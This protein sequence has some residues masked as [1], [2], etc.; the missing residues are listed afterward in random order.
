MP[1]FVPGIRALVLA[2]LLAFATLAHAQQQAPLVGIEPIR[3]ALDQIETTARRGASFR[4]FME[5]TQSLNPLRD[6]LRDKRADLDP[7]LADLDARLKSL[8][9][10]PAPNAPPED[11]AI[12]AERARITQQRSEIDAAIK[13]V[14]ELQTRADQLA[15][16][17][18]ERRR[19]AYSETL[20]R[21]S[22]NVLDP[23]FW[24]QVAKAL[25][26]EMDR[27]SNFAGD[28]ATY[29]RDK[30]GTARLASAGLALF[31]LMI[32]IIALARWWRR[33][34][35]IGRVGTRYGKALAALLVFARS[36]LALPLTVLIVVVLLDQFQLASPELVRALTGLIYGT[37]VASLARAT[38][39]SVLAPDDPQRRLLARDDATAQ[40]Q[41]THLIWGG[42]VVGAVV[43]LRALHSAI[44]TPA[45]IDLATRMLFAFAIATLLLHLL[46][47]RREAEDETQQ[48]Q[49]IPGVRLLAWLMIGAIVASL[50]AGY[51][52]FAAFIAGRLVFTITLIGILYLLLIVTD[53]VIARTMSAQTAGGR[54]LA[55]QLGIEPRRLDL[56]G[57]IASGLV[58]ALFVLIVIA[59]AL[60][61]WEIAASDLFD[62]L[63]GV[64][65]GIRIGDFTISFGALFG[66]IALF[67]VIAGLTKLI[68][69][70]LESEVM[71]HTAIEPSL[72]LSTVT[73]L[74]YIGYIIAVVVSLS[75]IGID[76]QKIA[77]VAG[78]LSVGIGFGL[79]S[80]VSNFVSG[81]ILLAERPIRVGDQI[82][83][84]SEEG[85]VRR[86][87]VRATEIETFER[88]SV[89]IPNSE[90]ITGVVKNWTHANTLGRVNIK[91]S[92][93]YASDPDKVMAILRACIIQHPEVL[94][95]PEPAIQLSEFGTSAMTFDI[96]CIVP[97]L[98]DRGRIKSDLH[99]AILREFRVSG[100]EMAPPQ[101]VRLIGGAA[102][103]GPKT[104]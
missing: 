96:F 34:A 87:S 12:A 98:A 41:A 97:N 93:S 44:A 74:G 33:V 15:A 27:L 56:F 68:Q 36:A 48:A 76:P 19:A 8:G 16:R 46:I 58:R 3:A 70:W 81:L 1:R 21:R 45:P 101:D 13:Q 40:W 103:P 100:V 102:A 60:G 91:V 31:G 77:L 17:L 49:R 51:A 11:A 61:R 37:A 32:L 30:G 95:Q 71:P 83:V 43:V 39:L 94:K 99:I 26:D 90:L 84:K 10:P 35:L 6:S 85:F 78:A 63:R 73:I 2:M 38:A 59:L 5:L 69:R 67:L 14:Q 50:L 54:V 20:F 65:L 92:V 53:A 22:A 25:P 72:Q 82:V 104:S 42:R 80:I 64:A 47:G 89:I 66:A 55:R 29:A 7:R 88:A 75:E 57:R 4:T 52:S 9:P 23:Y 28:I 24:A 18:S 62:A 79:Q 86:I